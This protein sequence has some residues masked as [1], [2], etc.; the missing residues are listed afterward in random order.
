MRA[1]KFTLIYLIL[2]QLLLGL[3]LPTGLIYHYRLDF[4][5]VKNSPAADYDV[6]LEKV[7]QEIKRDKLTDY[8]IILG[9]SVGYSGPGGPEQSIGYYLEE[10]GRQQGRSTRV[11]N[12]SMPAMQAGDLYTAFLM[13]QKHDIPARHVLVNIIYGGF[14]ARNPDP[15]AATWL[16]DDLK[17]LDP[18]AYD[19]AVPSLEANHRLKRPTLSEWFRKT[20]YPRVAI[21]RYR[22]FIRAAIDKYVPGVGP[23]EVVDT[24]PWSA[25]PGLAGLLQARE[26]QRLFDDTPFVMDQS[27]PQVYFIDRLIARAKAQGTDLMFFLTPANAELMWLNV[28]KPGYVANL[29]R[30]DAFFAQRSARYVDLEGTISPALFADH[31]HLIPEGYRQL[32]ILL[33]R[34]YFNSAA[35]P[36]PETQD[37]TGG[38][39]AVALP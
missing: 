9:D 31:L 26:Y 27:N 25:K 22:D 24:R 23:D 12:L 35:G 28:T 1:L 7:A 29:K 5:V 30:I 14:V 34:D 32:A 16:Q 6:V 11:F 37:L 3:V 38:G 2:V 10:I 36:R 4:N 15:P 18:G 19:Y 8:L 17:H 20:I 39:I 21:L 33:W 13:L